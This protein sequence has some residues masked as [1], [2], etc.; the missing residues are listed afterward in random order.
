M[1]RTKIDTPI[2]PE[3]RLSASHRIIGVLAATA[4]LMVGCGQKNQDPINDAAIVEIQENARQPEC[5]RVFDSPR[6]L[7]YAALQTP[8]YIAAAEELVR[9]GN[10]IVVP[11]PLAINPSL[12]AESTTLSHNQQIVIA[13]STQNMVNYVDVPPVGIGRM[14]FDQVLMCDAPE[15]RVINGEP[16]YV[17]AP[18]HSRTAVDV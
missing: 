10:L 9:G 16:A 11:E 1:I 7:A 6:S 5:R 8:E 4:A 2:A 12:Q 17:V 13:R 18:A 15:G 14:P 3:R